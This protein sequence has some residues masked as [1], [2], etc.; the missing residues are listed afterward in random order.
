M[1]APALLGS[2]GAGVGTSCWRATGRRE[3]GDWA[4]DISGVEEGWEDG[5]RAS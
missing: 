5:P 3:R 1:F 4:I 2:M